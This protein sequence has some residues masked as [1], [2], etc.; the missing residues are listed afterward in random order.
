LIIMHFTESI[1]F[2]DQEVGK[3]EEVGLISK[4]WNLHQCLPGPLARR[5]CCLLGGQMSI[6]MLKQILIPKC[7]IQLSLEMFSMR[8]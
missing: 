2:F 7:R 1:Q 6:R 4:S 5:V 3:R 8:K